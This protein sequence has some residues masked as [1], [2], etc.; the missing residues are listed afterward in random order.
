[1][2]GLS[3]RY[4]RTVPTSDCS[5]QDQTPKVRVSQIHRKEYGTNMKI[6][7]LQSR[8]CIAC[9]P[10]SLHLSSSPECGCGIWDLRI[11]LTLRVNTLMWGLRPHRF[12]N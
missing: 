11:L 12:I 8:H 5:G 10:A 1:M 9:M 2:A 4:A 3:T 7:N 6:L